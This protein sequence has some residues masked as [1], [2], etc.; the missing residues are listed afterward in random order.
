MKAAILADTGQDLF[1][2]PMDPDN[3]PLSQWSTHKVAVTERGFPNVGFYEFDMDDIDINFDY[4]IFANDAVPTNWTV[5]L[6]QL[7]FEAQ[8][9]EQAQYQAR[10]SIEESIDDVTKLLTGGKVVQVAPVAITGEIKSPVI[11]GDD[12][13]TETGRAFKWLVSGVALDI[14][15]TTGFFG[16][17][18]GGTQAFLIEGD[19]AE[20]TVGGQDYWEL[21]FDLPRL[22]SSE[23]KE[24]LYVYS[25][26]LQQSD[27]LL[28]VNVAVG[29]LKAVR[30][31]VPAPI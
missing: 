31:A 3:R 23:L 29:N 18:R 6:R 7:S 13:T 26:E 10:E 16:A 14:N 19:I 2:Y 27:P 17:R 1:L 21:T 24:T 9:L 20:V 5:A 4:A 30:D 25:V 8:R 22:L 12:Y 11:I 15:K 28:I